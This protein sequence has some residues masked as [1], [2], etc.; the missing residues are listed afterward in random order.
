VHL[1]HHAISLLG[2]DHPDQRA[3]FLLGRAKGRATLREMEGSHADIAEALGL[4]QSLDDAGL[5]AQ[6]LTVRGDVEQRE[7]NLDTSAATLEEAVSVWRDVG[8]RRGEAEALRLWGFTSIHRGHLDAAEQAIS[9]ALEISRLLGDRRGEAWAL[10]N[11]AWVPFTRGDNDL[12][13]QRLLAA[14]NLFEEIGD[15]GGRSW[16]Q[17]LLGY[18]WYFKGRLADAGVVAE[19]GIEITRESGDRWAHGMMINLLAGVRLW[20][21]RTKEALERATQGLK[22]FEE[23]HDDIG[24]QFASVAVAMGRV[25]TG[26]RDEALAMVDGYLMQPGNI[27]GGL[28]GVMTATAIHSLLGEGEEAVRIFD[29]HARDSD[30]PDVLTARAFALLVAGR[31]DEA[32]E[33]VSRAWATNPTD[34]GSRAN[35]ASMLSLSAAASGRAAEAIAAGEEVGR[36]GGTYLD[37]IRAHLGRAFGFAQLGDDRRARSALDS[38][39][40]IVEPSEDDLHSALVRLATGVVAGVRGWDDAIPVSDALESVARLGVVAEAWEKLFR[41]SAS[42]PDQASG[43]FA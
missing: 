2:D 1:L 43:L 39:R 4:A 25:L 27:F 40:R 37:Q 30:D 7:G 15:F 10:Q 20:Q 8:D 38:A 41:G 22:L 32:Y 18:I 31:A 17:G 16:A 13:E 3:K 35:Y 28:G 14:T 5:R 21:G 36:V 6:A 9:D 42:A 26:R 24:F 11:L 29:S 34:A 33:C 19:G 23:I 12:A